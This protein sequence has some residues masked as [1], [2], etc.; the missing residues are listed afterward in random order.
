MT[1]SVSRQLSQNYIFFC[2]FQ[3]Q[4]GKYSHVLISLIPQISARHK[5]FLLAAWSQYFHLIPRVRTSRR[6]N[7]MQQNVPAF[8][9]YANHSIL[10]EGPS[11]HHLKPEVIWKSISLPVLLLSPKMSCSMLSDQMI[12]WEGL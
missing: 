10:S 4:S 7:I 3:S 5:C 2:L 1:L 6:Q 9:F 12:Y 8:F 11:N